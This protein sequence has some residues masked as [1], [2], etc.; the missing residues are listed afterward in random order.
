MFLYW[1]D[2]SGKWAG[3]KGNTFSASLSKK[4]NILKQPL[5][6][7]WIISDLGVLDA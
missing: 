7:L 5:E 3:K 1:V 6:S 4:K 2:V